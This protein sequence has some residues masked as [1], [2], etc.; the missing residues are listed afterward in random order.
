MCFENIFVKNT[1]HVLTIY[2]SPAGDFNQFL[3]TTDNNR[4]FLMN[5]KTEVIICGDIY[6]NYL[7]E[8]KKNFHIKLLQFI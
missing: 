2:R 4:K 7:I 5:F 3:V 1:I 8:S 6:V